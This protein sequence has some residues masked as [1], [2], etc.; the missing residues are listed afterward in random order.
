MMILNNVISK[1]APLLAAIVTMPFVVTA[2]LAWAQPAHVE[3]THAGTVAAATK[4][5]TWD[6]FVR[7]ESDKYFKS[8][9]DLGGFGKFYNIRTPTPIDKQKVIRMALTWS[10]PITPQLSCIEDLSQ[11]GRN[12][13]R[14]YCLRPAAGAQTAAREPHRLQ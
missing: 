4:P 13:S 6:T 12:Q 1:K 7:A 10:D 8:Y 3:K 14:R 5:V 9:V 2:A 11:E